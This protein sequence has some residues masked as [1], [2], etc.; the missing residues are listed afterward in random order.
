MSRP[1]GHLE[2]ALHTAY[3]RRDIE[4]HLQRL[5]RGLEKFYGLEQAPGVEDFLRLGAKSSRE[6]LL[7]QDSADGIYVAVMFPADQIPQEPLRPSDDWTQLIEAVSHF[8]FLAERARVELPTTHLELELQAE[9]DKF[10]VLLPTLEATKHPSVEG[11]CIGGRRRVSLE[12]LRDLHRYLYEDVSFLHSIETD[13]GQ[14]YRLANQ[15]AAQYVFRLLDGG[16]PKSW[17]E[18]LR[19]FYR[20]GQAEKISLVLAAR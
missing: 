16:N 13:H 17:Q 14:R 5:Q 6:Q 19:A 8:L 15:L 20:A 3:E 9:I 2:R 7:V 11:L 18:R 12:A 10:V 1:D 4:H